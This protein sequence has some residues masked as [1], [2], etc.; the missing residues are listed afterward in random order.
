MEGV[1]ALQNGGFLQRKISPP[2][3]HPKQLQKR[4]M[5]DLPPKA[6]ASNYKKRHSHRK[7]KMMDING[8]MEKCILYGKETTL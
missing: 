3:Q 4:S 5:N 1:T 6:P 8:D 2:Y 7:M